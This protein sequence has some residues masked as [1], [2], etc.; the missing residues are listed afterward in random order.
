MTITTAKPRIGFSHALR[1]RTYLIPRRKVDF[2]SCIEGHDIIFFSCVSGVGKKRQCSVNQPIHH[3][4][5]KPSLAQ[6]F[7]PADAGDPPK[8]PKVPSV[9]GKPD[10]TL[11]TPCRR[12][13]GGNP[14]C[15]DNRELDPG[16]GGGHAGNASWRSKI[17]E[18]GF[19]G[20]TGVVGSQLGKRHSRQRRCWARGLHR[21]AHEPTDAFIHPSVQKP[22]MPIGRPQLQP[23]PA[24]GRARLEAR[25]GSNRFLGVVGGAVR[26]L[27][28][29]S[30]DILGD[31]LVAGA[32]RGEQAGR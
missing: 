29:N 25:Q 24:S 20:S 19:V 17:L 14:R 6:P 12:A 31:I 1:T 7:V 11:P 16:E 9:S 23:S 4:F 22:G 3:S 30:N 18:L 32:L 15:R 13:E 21:T 10:P 8:T 26:D 5:N 28:G 2:I 27:L